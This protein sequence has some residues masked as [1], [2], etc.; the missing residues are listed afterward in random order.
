M[1]ALLLVLVGLALLDAPLFALVAAAA[2]L[3]FL[4]LTPDHAGMQ[5][6]LPLV[7][8]TEP[9]LQRQEFLAI[10]L[11]AAAGAVMTA[12]GMAT[13]LVA[14]ARA[15]FGWL[16]GGL[17]IAAVMACVFFAAVSG[18]SPVT[19]LAV[20][21][22]LVPALRKSGY[23]E[24]F[25]IGLVTTAGSLG[26]LVP[27]AQALLI[28]AASVTTTSARVDP[29][30]LFL[31]GLVPAV[32]IALLLCGFAIWQARRMLTDRP[33]F[34]A[35]AMRTALR[36]GIWALL[37]PVVV[38]GGIWGGFYTPSEAGAVASVYA[39]VVTGLIHR[40]LTWRKL[41]DALAE[42]GT[43]MG[44]LLVVLI[45]AFA[46]GDFLADAQVQDRLVTLLTGWHLGPVAFLVLVNL[47][48]VGIGALTD[49]ISCTLLFAP[50][51]API[52]VEVYGIDPLHFA[53]VFVANMEI[54]YLMPP[55][56]TN[57]FVAS[58]V[59]DRP[60]GYMAKAVAPTLALLCLALVA[61]TFLPTLATGLVRQQRGQPIV[62]A[63]PWAGAQVPTQPPVPDLASLTVQA[64]ADVTPT[65][66][67][68][69]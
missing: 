36:E 58:A 61:L 45:L 39:L 67:P 11:F 47:A 14:V 25:S 33:G 28:Y 59:F 55:V 1:I 64:F 29:Q 21:P 18:S 6:L 68:I 3:C 44:T 56:A 5:G 19:L 57:L 53:I 24:D 37:L 26:C 7:Q 2:A 43:L 46:L 27:P 31:A 22:L 50:L 42:A 9:L 30:E 63:F 41:T 13:R 49:S 16:P 62:Q 10:P 51:L 66:Q 32:G 34:D 23:R 35:L 8:S 4:W 54:G 69:P 60:L 38:L 20:G 48:L 52:A 40:E 65:A 15:A 17:A 12:G